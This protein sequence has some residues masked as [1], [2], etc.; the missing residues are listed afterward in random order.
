MK[1]L[2]NPWVA[3][4][5]F[6]GTLLAIGQWFIPIAGGAYRWAS[7][8]LKSARG[9]ADRTSLEAP[10]TFAYASV[11]AGGGIAGTATTKSAAWGP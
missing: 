1:W 3:L 9:G 10:A 11:A 8:L 2:S 6:L 5:E 7:G 4:I